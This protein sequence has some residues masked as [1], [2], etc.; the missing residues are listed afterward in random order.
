MFKPVYALML[1]GSLLVMAG[2]DQV[3]SSSRQLLDTAA[4]SAK[5]AIDDTHKAAVQALDEARQDMSVLEPDS[6]PERAH[7]QAPSS[8]DI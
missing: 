4:E 5:Q 8:R 7:E 1:A 3:E 6:R 2:C